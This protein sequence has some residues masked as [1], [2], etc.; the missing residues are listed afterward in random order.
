MEQQF[1]QSCGIPLTDEN[2]ATNA[3]GSRSE[4]YCMYCYKNGAFTP[5]FH[6]GA[7]D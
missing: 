7:N 5:G 3:N 4:D 2:R 1:C 6:D